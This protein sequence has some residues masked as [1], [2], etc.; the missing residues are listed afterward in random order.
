LRKK[1]IYG[2]RLIDS[3]APLGAKKRTVHND[4]KLT[5]SFLFY[6]STYGF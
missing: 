4:L 3:E 2:W 5:K 6:G 1:P